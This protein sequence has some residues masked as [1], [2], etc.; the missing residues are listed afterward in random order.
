MPGDGVID[1]PAL[2]G[3]VEAAGYTG[4]VE[5]ELLSRRW[6]AEDPDHVLATMVERHASVC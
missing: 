2:R 4:F 1:I 3:M 5:I 6:W